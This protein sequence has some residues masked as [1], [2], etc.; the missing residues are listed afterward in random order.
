MRAADRLVARGVEATVARRLA[1]ASAPSA[2]EALVE[3]FDREGGHT[4]GWLVAALR[5]GYGASAPAG[6]GLMSYAEMLAE[7]DRTGRRTSAYE[8][9]HVEGEAKPLW[10][11]RPAAAESR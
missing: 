8:A 11:R 6:G 9:V 5:D 1:T 7:C 4:P 2:V 10:R 3:R